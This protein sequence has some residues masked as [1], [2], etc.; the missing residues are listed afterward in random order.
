M[1]P[2]PSEPANCSSPKL[3]LEETIPCAPRAPL[4][5][6]STIAGEKGLSLYLAKEAIFVVVVEIC[7]C[8]APKVSLTLVEV[9]TNSLP[10]LSI[11]RLLTG[12]E[13]LN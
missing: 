13:P 8:E 7:N 12:A 6:L 11:T 3:S 10:E 5:F 1:K 4:D 2:D 9:L